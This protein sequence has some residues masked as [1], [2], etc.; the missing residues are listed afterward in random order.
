MVIGFYKTH[1]RCA[2]ELDGATNSASHYGTLKQSFV[3]KKLRKNISNP[4]PLTSS[5]A[6]LDINRWSFEVRCFGAGSPFLNDPSNDDVF[7][8]SYLPV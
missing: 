5:C 6:P 7:M 1:I 4:P 8:C 3:Q 2:C